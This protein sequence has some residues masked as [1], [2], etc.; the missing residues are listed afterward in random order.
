MEM[1]VSILDRV[2]PAPPR[3]A[4]RGKSSVPITRLVQRGLQWTLLISLSIGTY[5]LINRY[6]LQSVR[7]QGQ[8]MLPT[9]HNEDSY[10]LNRWIYCLRMPQRGDVVVLKD[11][12]DG[13]YAVKRIIALAGDS[14]YLKSGRVYVNGQ[15]LDEP[16]LISGTPTYPSSPVNEEMVV[17]GSDRYFVM[18]DNRNNSFDSRMYGP[19]PRQNILGMIK[20]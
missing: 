6:V 11:P 20:L 2:E 5:L 18:G 17:C 13:C 8:S 12:S 1:A 10:Y 3:V 9:L 15:V 7:V 14:V 16:Y 19:V 4:S